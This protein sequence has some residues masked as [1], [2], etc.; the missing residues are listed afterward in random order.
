MLIPLILFFSN[1]LL[2]IKHVIMKKFLLSTSMVAT[3]ILVVNLVFAQQVKQA[4]TT[5][6]TTATKANATA[7]KVKAVA[8]TPK[9]AM[10]APPAASA[11]VSAV[12]NT[13]SSA[14]DAAQSGTVADVIGA[15]K[16]H[17]TLSTALKAAGLTDA[18]KGAGPFTVF[19]PTNDAFAKV[20]AA[21]LDNLL[22]PEN[23]ETLSKVLTTHVVAGSL[24]AADI[25]AA[26]KAG[27]GTASFS[28]LSGEKLTA[29][30]EGDKVKITDSAGNVAIV[31]TADI[32]ADNGVIH[33]ID[34]VLAGK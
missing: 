31:S 1:Y 19:A 22:K 7:E 8:T 10:Q 14:A 18:L 17:S 23:K 33:V 30:A 11:E 3:F 34:N 21:A 15:S 29:S 12:Q 26:I 4:V 27:N 25:L 32:G 28:S 2:N 16:A 5:A 24:K 9:P 20:P 13:A 6:K